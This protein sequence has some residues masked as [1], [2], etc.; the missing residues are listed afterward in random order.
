MDEIGRFY[1]AEDR[2]VGTHLAL[3]WNGR[4]RFTVPRERA[5]QQ[6]CWRNFHPGRLGL[7][8]RAI[9]RLPWLFGAISCGEAA[10]LIEIRELLGSGAGLSCCRAG[11]LRSK[12]TILFLD[13]RTVRPQYI[14]KV[15]VGAQADFF[16]RNEANWLRSLRDQPSLAIHIPELVQ[17]RSGEDFSFLAQSPL[18]GRIDFAFGESHFEFLLKL[19]EWSLRPIRYEDSGLYRALNSRI[20][21]LDGAL[22]IEWSTRI[23]RGMRQIEQSF[24]GSTLLSVAAHNDFT[25]WNVRIQSRRACVFDWEH[26]ANEQLP[27]F[28][29]LHFALLP[30][31]LN[32]ESP[33]RIMRTMNR[34]VQRCRDRFGEERCC[35][36]EAQSLTYLLNLCT[37]YLWT[38]HGEYGTHPILD[39]YAVVIDHLCPS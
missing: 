14:V 19:H 11:T 36:A 12:D 1:K 8:L 30:M 5:A 17:F 6:A 21:D 33:A 35:Q 34:T 4:V 9:A 13:N 31:A 37:L 28:D 39:T 10:N 18:S 26:A 3:R 29:P 22:T 2:A 23:A 24:S 20:N 38:V 27:L 15:G 7:P 16:L 25:P 32:R